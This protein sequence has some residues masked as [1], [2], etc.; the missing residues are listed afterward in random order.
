VNH[1]LFVIASGLSPSEIYNI[2]VDPATGNTTGYG[3]APYW[4][5]YGMF[6]PLWLSG[7]QSLLFTAAGTYFSTSNLNYI[8]TFNIGGAVQSMLR[9]QA[10]RLW[11]VGAIA[12]LPK[13]LPA[14]DNCPVA[15]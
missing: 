11:H 8:G 15:E 7:D 5:D 3:Q 14:L 2:N 4:G 10:A 1:K 12:K 13:P 9:P 6:A